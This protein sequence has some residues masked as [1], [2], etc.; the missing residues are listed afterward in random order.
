M[1]GRNAISWEQKFELDVWYVEH[2]SFQLDCKIVVSTFLKVFKSEGISQD[3]HVTMSK[4]TGSV[5]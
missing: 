1:N 2:L 4:F 3:G 5:H